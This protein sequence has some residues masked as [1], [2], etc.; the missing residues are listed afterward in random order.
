MS[1]KKFLSSILQVICKNLILRKNNELENTSSASFC[2][3]LQ[4][5]IYFSHQTTPSISHQ[6]LPINLLLNKLE[7]RF[8]DPTVS[9]RPRR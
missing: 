1:V 5:Q 3:S 8:I 2:N 6:A 4:H 7:K 9:P